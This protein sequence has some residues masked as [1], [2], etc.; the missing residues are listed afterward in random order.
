MNF[1]I[2]LTHDAKSV[3]LDNTETTLL[4]GFDDPVNV[5]NKWASDSYKT[6]SAKYNKLTYG[7]IKD[8]CLNILKQYYNESIKNSDIFQKLILLYK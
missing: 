5:L 4:A 8:Q 3:K 2:K 7:D 1:H 6:Y